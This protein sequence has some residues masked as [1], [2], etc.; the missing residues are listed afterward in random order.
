MLIQLRYAKEI[1]IKRNKLKEFE[2]REA[3][4]KKREKDLERA[5]GEA[6]TEEDMKLVSDSVDELEAEK[7]QLQEE[8][9]TIEAEMKVVQDKLDALNEKRS[10]GDNDD[11]I[12]DEEKQ[13]QERGKRSMT[14]QSYLKLRHVKEFY[15]Q[16]REL[17][18]RGVTGQSITVPQE[19][20]D[21]V[22]I[23]V[24]DY[25]TLYPL[26]DRI[27]VKGTARILLDV[28]EEGAV[29]MEMVGALPEGDTGSITNIDFDGFKLGK[30]TAIDN[31]FLQDSII[32]LDAYV[33]KKIAIAI[34]KSLDKAILKGEGAANKQPDG[35]IP[36]LNADNKVG[37]ALTGTIKDIAKI[38][39]PIGLID[40]GEE[41]VGE[42]VAVMKRKTYYNRIV[43]MN[44]G[45]ASDGIP[46]AKLPN[47]ANPTILGLRVVFN[48]HMDEDQ[49]LYGDFQ[50]YTLVEREDITIERSEHAKFT[51]DQLAIRGKGR[52]DGKP[53]NVDAFVLVTLSEAAVTAAKSK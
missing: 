41:S 9:T 37:V 8:K 7:A 40:D 22:M 6:E 10:D 43:A 50:K 2:T 53:T 34:A 44:M 28:S 23:Q 11:Q 1:E 26:V 33:T 14:K 38:V 48:Q 31:A 12:E 39:A 25:T 24:G 35:I 52:F 42:I 47:L 17:K 21:H 32:N 49:I 13:T 27:K 45:E 20:I 3:D 46:N 19:V 36:K 30:I 29:W 51:Q 4:F 15:T 16:L 5:L 18:T